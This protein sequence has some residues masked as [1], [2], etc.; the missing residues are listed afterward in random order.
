MY[1]PKPRIR[2]FS[3]GSEWADWVAGNCERCTRSTVRQAEPE[4]TG[5]LLEKALVSA[6]YTDGEVTAYVAET[7]GRGSVRMEHCGHRN[8]TPVWRAWGE[9]VDRPAWRV[10]M[11]LR[12]QV[13]GTRVWLRTWRRGVC[14]WPAKA[15]EWAH[16]TTFDGS[17]DTFG[18]RAGC[19]IAWTICRPWR[20]RRDC[21]HVALMHLRDEWMAAWVYASAAAT[22]AE[23]GTTNGDGGDAS[24]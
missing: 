9:A 12:A 6:Y 20:S 22:A 3:S 23:S 19:G 15:R 17:G 14:S 13:R 10:W 21:V 18:W 24:C 5:C 7:I 11:S 1:V 8:L 16:T 4:T 2:P